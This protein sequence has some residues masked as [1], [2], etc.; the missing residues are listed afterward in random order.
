MTKQIIIGI[1]SGASATKAKSPLGS[2]MF[3]TK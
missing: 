1:D 3:A 2:M